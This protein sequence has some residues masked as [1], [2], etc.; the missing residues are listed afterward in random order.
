MNVL[1]A[2]LLLAGMSFNAWAG[3]EITVYKSPTCGCCNK[4]VKHLEDN[5]FDVK[6]KNVTDVIPYKIKYGVTPQL[7]SCH[8]A[9][10]DGYTIEGHV[11]ASDIKRLLR[12]KP[13]LQGISVPQMPVGTP[14]M[15]QGDRKDPYQVISFDRDGRTGIFTDYTK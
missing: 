2:T 15:E 8:T 11:P 7:A 9:V 10:V 13:A 14:G 12:E 3:L 1:A 6:A 5:G 4:W